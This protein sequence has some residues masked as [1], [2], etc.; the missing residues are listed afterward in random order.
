[1]Y[2]ILLLL[3]I[4]QSQGEA[5]SLLSSG[6]R[7]S[8]T[9][10][11][12]TGERC[13]NATHYLTFTGNCTNAVL[14]EDVEQ[15]SCSV[16][17]NGEGPYC[18][19]CD[20]VKNMVCSG[21]MDT[22]EACADDCNDDTFGYAFVDYCTSES[23]WMTSEASCMYGSVELVFAVSGTCAEATPDMPMCLDC[24]TVGVC[25]EPS[26]TCESLGISGG[27]TGDW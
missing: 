8:S 14:L 3:F 6:V 5:A 18:H 23:V 15:Q 11:G 19:E 13:I 20:S 1:M 17:T 9:Q 7:C 10:F 25:A 12:F 27:A 24:N 22:A 16:K 21:T 2:F 26:A 4:V